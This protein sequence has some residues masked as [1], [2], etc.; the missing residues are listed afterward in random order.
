VLLSL[1]DVRAKRAEDSE[2]PKAR[3]KDDGE[4]ITKNSSRQCR[5]SS[6]RR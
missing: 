1:T 3:L 5:H 2:L 6:T 4:Q